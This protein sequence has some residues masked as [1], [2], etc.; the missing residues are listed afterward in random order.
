MDTTTNGLEALTVLLGLDEFEVVAINTDPKQ[1]KM[2]LVLVPRATTGLCP[3]CDV[4]CGRCHRSHERKIVDLPI[5]RCF[6]ELTVCCYQFECWKCH[7][8]FTPPYRSI[9]EGTHATER[10]L[11]RMA[12][13]IGF[14]DIANTARFFGVAEKT[15]EAWYYQYVERQTQARASQ[16]IR[17]MGIDELSLKKNIGSSVAC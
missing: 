9:A 1:A 8:F 11:E 12:Q 6:T 16:P 2:S 17:S 5:G 7:R 10:F 4:L 14:S 13:M 15:L 3:H